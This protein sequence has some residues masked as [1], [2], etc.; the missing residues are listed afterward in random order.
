V[1]KTQDKEYLKKWGFK[2]MAQYVRYVKEEMEDLEFIAPQAFRIFQEKIGEWEQEYL[3]DRKKR[4]VAETISPPEDK[5][6]KSPERVVEKILE[7]WENHRQWKDLPAK[8]RGEEPTKYDPKDFLRTM[9]DLIRFRILC[10]YLT[11]IN[12]FDRKIQDFAEKSGCIKLLKR[13]N[14]IETPFPKRR[15][16]HRA[17]QYAFEYTHDGRTALFEVQLM[18]QLAHAWDKKDHHLIY[19]YDRIGRGEEIPLHLRNRMAAMS[20]VLYVADTVFDSL[21]SKITKIMEKDKK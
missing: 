5:L 8:D 13:D 21:R 17:L 20:E 9:T 2:N 1:N 14:H 6:T 18:T 12:W 15:V 4:F 10:N 16:G 11:D 19:E 7:S 3:R